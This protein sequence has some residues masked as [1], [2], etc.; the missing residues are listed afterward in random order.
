MSWIKILSVVG[1]TL[2][3]VTVV[4]LGISIAQVSVDLNRRINGDNDPEVKKLIDEY[5]EKG[6]ELDKLN[7][8]VIQSQTDVT[9][10]NLALN[11]IIGL[12]S[13]FDEGATLVY[14]KANALVQLRDQLR[15]LV[16]QPDFAWYNSKILPNLE[17]FS[18]EKQKEIIENYNKALTRGGFDWKIYVGY[19]LSLVAILTTP[20]IY[21]GIGKK[22]Q[23]VKIHNAPARRR[24]IRLTHEEATIL[25]TKIKKQNTWYRRTGRSIKAASKSKVALG[26][27][28]LFMFSFNLYTFISGIIAD[29][30]TK[31]AIKNDLRDQI[32]DIEKSTRI[33]TT[34]V[35]GA[36]DKID[37]KFVPNEE[38]LKELANNFEEIKDEY[39]SPK[40]SDEEN[41]DIL[42]SW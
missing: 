32:T 33:L 31:K 24:A 11:N 4:D 23:S 28:V 12:R 27:L 1:T 26:G 16:T 9:N 8:R 42:K 3:A 39:I 18:E 25:R 37:G 22:F 14:E 15:S 41:E 13:G 38:K 40:C 19:S 6:E 21:R 36:N 29:K 5:L 2:K 30:K 20:Y 10:L 34:L 35:E 17:N 7:S